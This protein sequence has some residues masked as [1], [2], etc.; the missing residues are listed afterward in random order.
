MV[1]FIRDNCGIGVGN[2]KGGMR[3]LWGRVIS[4]SPVSTFHSIAVLSA[5]LVAK[6]VVSPASV[7]CNRLA[8]NRR[9]R[10]ARRS[11]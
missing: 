9:R 10:Q 4:F 11:K 5:E 8:Q 2:G 1:R 7:P 6:I 3:T